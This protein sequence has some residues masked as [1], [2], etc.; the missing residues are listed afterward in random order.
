MNIIGWSKLKILVTGGA[1]YIGS[2]VCSALEESGH[3][4]IVIDSLVT[5]NR[6]Y[7]RDRAFY[8][9]DIAD[10]KSLKMVMGEHPDIQAV[11]HCA[12][13]IIVPE[14]GQRPYEYYRENV[15][16][17]IE[18]F[19]F[20][21]ENGLNRI[22]FS[23][24]AALYKGADGSM[25]TESSIL[26][27]NS[28]YARTKLSVEMVLQDYCNA[29]SLRAISLRYFNPIG[30]DPKMRSG[31]HGDNPTHILGKLISVANRDEPHFQVT[32]TRWP[33][34][35]GTGIRDYIHVWDL[36][37]AH[38][39]AVEE[40]EAVTSDECPFLAINLGTGKGVTVLEFIKAFEE[41]SGDDIPQIDA[42]PRAGDSAGAYASG[43]LAN[44]LLG[45][46][47]R[48]SLEQGVADAIKWSRKVF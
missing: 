43:E 37:E 12:A 9:S 8:H 35:D 20:L 24:T 36:A 6:D 10:V 3:E 38:V 47:P 18:L 21:T 23:S 33:T 27:P 32:G 7:V 16:K 28:P 48:M 29:Y 14:S 22:V 5:G 4:P 13:L 30:A 42:D 44:E 17:S 11:I 31:P 34:R 19:H 39:K 46:A 45:W 15:S 1:G 40:F 25:V 41:V 2:T 26:E